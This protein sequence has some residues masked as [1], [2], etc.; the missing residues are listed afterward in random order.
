M[1]VP[2]SS[3]LFPCRISVMS[4]NVWGGKHWPDRCTALKQVFTSLRPDVMMLQEM[5]SSIAEAITSCMP[6]HSSLS[7]QLEGIFIVI[8]I[9]EQPFCF[10]WVQCMLSYTLPSHLLLWEGCGWSNF[11]PR[12]DTVYPKQ[13]LVLAGVIFSGIVL[14][15]IW[16]KV[17]FVVL[18]ILTIRNEG[19]CGLGSRQRHRPHTQEPAPA[20]ADFL[21]CAV[22][23]I[24]LIFL[25]SFPLLLLQVV[26]NTQELQP[27][28]ADF[29][30]CTVHLP[31][32]GCRTGELLL[33][34]VCN[35]HVLSHLLLIYKCKLHWKGLRIVIIY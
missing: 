12:N 27:A 4:Y 1:S 20:H 31:W 19:S 35:F 18:I 6:T 28:H 13:A 30:V 14:C 26:T 21:V 16:R 17:G 5:T 33:I 2:S 25:P 11:I 7:V 8:S 29:L 34:Y 15:L 23:H 9:C 22:H 24:H 3:K 32:A 10:Q